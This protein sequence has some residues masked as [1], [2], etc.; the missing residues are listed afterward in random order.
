MCTA[1]P[2]TRGNGAHQW[3]STQQHTTTTAVVAPPPPTSRGLTGVFRASCLSA[4]VNGF[5]TGTNWSR[6]A[7]YRAK[8]ICT[9]PRTRPLRILA[10]LVARRGLPPMRPGPLVDGYCSEFVPN[11]FIQL[12]CCTLAHSPR[13]FQALSLRLSESSE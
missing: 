9:A 13:V 7:Y 11:S 10:G 1:Q 2:S 5:V 12:S 4:R 8:E 3:R 6:H